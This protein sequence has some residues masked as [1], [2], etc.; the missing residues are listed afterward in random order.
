MKRS[1]LLSTAALGIAILPLGAVQAQDG[2]TPFDN[3]GL[4]FGL[5]AGGATDTFTIEEEGTMMVLGTINGFAGGLILGNRFQHLPGRPS[6]AIE[7]EVG[8]TSFGENELQ[9]ADV[10]ASPVQLDA[11]VEVYDQ[12]AV[13]RAR[14][15]LGLPMGN[16]EPFVAVGGSLADVNVYY[17]LY[18]GVG[19]LAG[20]NVGI[21][22][23]IA[24]GPNF[25]LRPEVIYDAYFDKTYGEIT[26]DLETFTAR[27]AAI[28][29]LPPGG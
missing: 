8:F 10:V 21:G 1:L 9:F 19:T 14:I 12:D 15:L 17:E 5:Y 28:L 11:A 20:V 3:P 25:F 22:A 27:L 6:V 23:N 16:V 24:M 26:V 2:P 18:S 4:Y 7:A 13:A 29:R